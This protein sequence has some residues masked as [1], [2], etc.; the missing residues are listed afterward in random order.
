MVLFRVRV[1]V[2]E[3]CCFLRKNEISPYPST[4]TTIL[5]LMCIVERLLPLFDA[6]CCLEPRIYV[7]ITID[8]NLGNERPEPLS[9][10]MFAACGRA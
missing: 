5:I 9:H 10:N 2:M 8:T 4:T 7:M 6:L 1:G 3:F